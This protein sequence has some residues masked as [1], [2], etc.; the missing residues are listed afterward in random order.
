M[1]E[2]KHAS[3]DID[4]AKCQHVVPQFHPL[5]CLY[6]LSIHTRQLFLKLGEPCLNS[7]LFRLEHGQGLCLSRNELPIGVDFVKESAISKTQRAAHAKQE[8]NKPTAPMS[9]QAMRKDTH[10]TDPA[11]SWFI[12]FFRSEQWTKDDMGHGGYLY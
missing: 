9:I 1:N 11:R 8:S 3:L 6:A 2:A 5:L 10:R 12:V 4:Y 7:M